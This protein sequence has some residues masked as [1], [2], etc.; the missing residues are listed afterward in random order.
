MPADRL[1]RARLALERGQRGRGRHRHRSNERGMR[2]ILGP[3]A[4]LASASPKLQGDSRAFN[5]VASRS[6]SMLP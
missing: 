1:S 5:V 2:L 3:M 4:I 6:M